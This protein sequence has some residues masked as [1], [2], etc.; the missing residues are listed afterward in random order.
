MNSTCRLSVIIAVLLLGWHFIVAQSNPGLENLMH[1]WTFNDGTANDNIATNPV[2]GEL[3]GGAY[4]SG[5]ALH[6]TA[7]GQYLSFPGAAL[8]LNTYEVISQEIWFTPNANANSGFSHLSYFGQTIGSSG[9][10]YLYVMPVRGDDMSRVGISDGSVAEAV[11]VSG[12]EINDGNLHHFVSVVRYDSLFFYI[13]G[14]LAEKKANTVPLSTISQSLALLGK[15]G[16]TSDPT[17]Q[18]SISKYS[19]FNKS[20]SPDEVKFLF[21]QGGEEQAAI[22]TSNSNLEF[23]EPSSKTVEVWA[24]NLTQEVSISATPGFSVSPTSLPANSNGEHVTITYNGNA[25][26]NG[27]IIFTSSGVEKRVS[28]SG[29]LNPRIE[30]SETRIA[31]DEMVNEATFFIT[32][33]NLSNDIVISVPAGI[34][35]SSN[36]VPANSRRTGITVLYDG[37]RNSSGTIF[38]SNGEASV[39]IELVAIRNDE[40]FTPLFAGNLINDPALNFDDSGI[41]NRSINTNP[42]FVYCGSSSGKVAGS[43]SLER[44]LTGLLKPN[45]TYKVKMKAYKYSPVI[46]PGNMG[47]V[48]YTLALDSAAYP[49]YYNLIK[50]AMDSACGYYSKYTPFIKDVYVYY[51][52]GIPTAQASHLGSIGFGSNTSYMWV[53]TAI[54]ELAHYFGSGTSSL[55]QSLMSSRVWAGESGTALVQAISGESLRGDSQ[56]FWP[57]G[58]NY[59]SEIT[60]LGS[61]DAQ[62]QGLINSVMVTKAMLVDDCNYNTYNSVTGIGIQGWSLN[63]EDIFYEIDYANQWENVEFTFTTGN[64]LSANQKIYFTGEEGYIDNWELYEVREVHQAEVSLNRGWNL[65]SLPVSLVDM[66]VERVFPH[67]SVV[68]TMTDYYTPSQP[69]FFNTLRTIEEG[70]GYL[71]YNSVNETLLYE[72]V[73]LVDAISL[74]SNSGTWQLIGSPWNNDVFIPDAF[75]QGI[76]SIGQI[77]NFDGFWQQNNTGSLQM[78]EAGKAYFVR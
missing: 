58:I 50:E 59:R 74:D 57:Y 1:Q 20:L 43:G 14:R 51:N 60:D 67:A 76:N 75:G 42:N 5:N 32:A 62:R 10:N 36:T 23:L 17:W 72:G 78:I 66:S 56:H 24:V 54:H 26:A 53:G 33:Y 12:P 13:D 27:E 48:T 52:D 18:G 11:Y 40:C 15:S 4:I 22:I 25:S 19:I 21:E 28:V 64:Q 70:R 63:A 35:V 55:W 73:S 68:K 71:V 38:I 39:H 47:H 2:N 7:E 41:G 29:S 30:V 37:V 49:Q 9:Y 31:L 65:V 61:H 8:A 69:L 77:K 44:N 6:L 34:S 3:R 46:K 16:F 45:T